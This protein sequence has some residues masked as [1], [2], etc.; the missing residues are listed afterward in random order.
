MDIRLSWLEHLMWSVMGF[1]RI[2]KKK[3]VIVCFLLDWFRYQIGKRYYSTE[4]WRLNEHKWAFSPVAASEMKGRVF[5]FNLGIHFAKILMYLLNFALIYE[6]ILRFCQNLGYSA[7][8]PRI[9]LAPPLLL[10]LLGN[11]HICGA[12]FFTLCGTYSVRHRSHA[13]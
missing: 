5:I 7:A 10:T 4:I 8:Y 9:P 1:C 3:L 12:H 6:E 11:L 13:T 2:G